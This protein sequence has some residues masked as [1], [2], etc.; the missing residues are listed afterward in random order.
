MTDDEYNYADF[1]EHVGRGAL[2]GFDTFGGRLHAG[3]R[4]PSFPLTR[5][6]DATTVELADLWRRTPTVIEFGSFT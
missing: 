6:D 3:Q 5:L 2:S 1:A 4:A